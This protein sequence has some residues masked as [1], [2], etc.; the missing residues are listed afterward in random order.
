MSAGD[1]VG[2]EGAA[3]TSAESAVASLEEEGGDDAVDGRGEVVG[4]GA[5][6]EEVLGGVGSG[7]EEEF[8]GE[9]AVGGGYCY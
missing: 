4:G 6:G 5:E 8:D 7:G 2:G 3:F 9:G 1:G